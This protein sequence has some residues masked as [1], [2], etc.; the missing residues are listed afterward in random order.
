MDLI[1]K[2]FQTLDVESLFH[3]GPSEDFPLDGNII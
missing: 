2:S 3:C 1:F